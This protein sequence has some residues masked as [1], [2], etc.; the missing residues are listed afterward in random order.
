MVTRYD[1]RAA[2]LMAAIFTTT[3]CSEDDVSGPS[4][5]EL[6]T[7]AMVELQGTRPAFYIQKSD[8]SERSRIHFTGALDEVPGNS[9]LVPAL[10]DENI[11]AIRSV[12]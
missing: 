2:L 12:K 3:A 1:F 10:T 9:P 5:P 6:A 8:G 11:L 4:A 7:V